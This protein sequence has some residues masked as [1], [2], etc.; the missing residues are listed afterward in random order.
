[1]LLC[2]T[3]RELMGVEN[4]PNNFDLEFV[5]STYD[6]NHQN[7]NFELFNLTSDLYPLDQDVCQILGPTVQPA[8]CK[9]TDR[10]Y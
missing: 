9:E 4:S 1:M 10:R 2:R 6:L 5:T 3:S 8:E 7:R